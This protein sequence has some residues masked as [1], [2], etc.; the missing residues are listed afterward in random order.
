MGPVDVDVDI[1]GVSMVGL[2]DDDVAVVVERVTVMLRPTP[3][4][5]L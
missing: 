2:L 5:Q 4:V 1:V 3:Q